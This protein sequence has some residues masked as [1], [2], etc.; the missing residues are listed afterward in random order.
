M[1]ETSGMCVC[2]SQLES[3]TLLYLFLQVD[4]EVE[5]NLLRPG[6]VGI[7][8]LSET[9]FLFLSCLWEKK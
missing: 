9:F 6:K 3:F 4:Q 8:F 1:V 2:V 7:F 5:G